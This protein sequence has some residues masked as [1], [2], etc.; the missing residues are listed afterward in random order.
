MDG[1]FDVSMLCFI[2]LLIWAKLRN[3]HPKSR[4]TETLREEET[5]SN[6]PLGYTLDLVGDQCV[7]GLRRDGEVV[8][9]TLYSKRWP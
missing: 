9:T 6:V 5:S 7:L 1:A 8:V 2:Y 4:G 3:V